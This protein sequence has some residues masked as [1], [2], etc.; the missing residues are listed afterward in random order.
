[1]PLDSE[2]TE[3]KSLCYLEWYDPKWVAD[4][5]KLL[6]IYRVAISINWEMYIE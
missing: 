3:F 6:L 5:I 2:G 1:M 4:F